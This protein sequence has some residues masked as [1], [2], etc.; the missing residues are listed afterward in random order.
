MDVPLFCS[1]YELDDDIS[2][3]LIAQG[4]KRTKTFRHITIEGLKD[5]AFKPGEIASLQVAVA[6]WADVIA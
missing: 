2:A 6:E 3:H 1:K 4:Y 5:M